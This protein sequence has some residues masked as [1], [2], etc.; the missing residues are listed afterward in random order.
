MTDG[1][2]IKE[3][4]QGTGNLY[5]VTFYYRKYIHFNILLNF[6]INPLR[7]RQ[8]LM[9]KKITDINLYRKYKE[10]L[11]SNKM[12]L[13]LH[14]DNVIRPYP[15]EIKEFI[16]PNK[17]SPKEIQKLVDKIVGMMKYNLKDKK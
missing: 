4:L 10:Y 9:S 15:E 14:S 16:E 11:N 2:T 1:I 12:K 13:Y 8:T 6:I 3:R 5:N 7:I 17:N